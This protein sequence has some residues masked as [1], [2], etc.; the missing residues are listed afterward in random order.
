MARVL[1][2]EDE[3][4]PRAAMRRSLER[5]GHSCQAVDN[6]SVALGLLRQED[7]EVMVSDISMP[8]M[9]GLELLAEVRQRSPQTQVVL[10]TGDPRLETAVEAVRLGAFDYLQKPVA[11]EHLSRVVSAAARIKRLEHE[12]QIYREHLEQLVESRS[13]SLQESLFRLQSILEGTVQALSHAMEMRDP[14]TAGHQ[15]RVTRLACAVHDRIAPRDVPREGLRIAGL[16]HDLGKLAI[17]AEILAKPSRLTP[18]EFALVQRHSELAWEILQGVDFPWP[19][20]DIVRQ[21]HERMDGSGYPDRLTGD[22]ICL[23]ARILG[24]CDVIEAMASHRPYRPALGI[25]AALA[26]AERGRGRLYD[27]AVVDACVYLFRE[28]GFELD[29]TEPAHQSQP[30]L[31]LGA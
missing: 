21:H 8:G 25:D 19:V 31:R 29:P 10:V 20:A 27:A 26:E 1:L 4:G 23:E 14:Y 17:P 9:T 6:P 15:R 7:F 12:N 24:V 18:V 16:L 13:Q 5:E 22:A 3:L 28:Q 11:D 2:V 30:A